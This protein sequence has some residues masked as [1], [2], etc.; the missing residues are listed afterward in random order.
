MVMDMRGAIDRKADQPMGVT[1]KVA[2]VVIDR[3]AIGLKS[4]ADALAVPTM[5]FLETD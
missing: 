3:E 4:V 5:L 2:P 1:K